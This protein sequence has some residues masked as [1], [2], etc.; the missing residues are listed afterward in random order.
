MP[1]RPPETLYFSRQQIIA[2]VIS[3]LGVVLLAYGWDAG[4]PR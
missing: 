4:S 1:A 3:G 2:L